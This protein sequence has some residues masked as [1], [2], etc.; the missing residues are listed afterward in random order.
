MPVCCDDVLDKRP[1]SSVAAQWVIQSEESTS[2][3]LSNV[4]KLDSLVE[5]Q[6]HTWMT[7]EQ[8]VAALQ[9]RMQVN[10][11]RPLAH[12]PTFAVRPPTPALLQIEL[13][14]LCSTRSSLSRKTSTAVPFVAVLLKQA[15]LQ[16]H[17]GS[18]YSLTLRCLFLK[19]LFM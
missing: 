7:C 17:H 9:M 1:G 13:R 5:P 6:R 3:T 11:A 16:T 2:G 4:L 14:V 15:C 12:W 10:S 19:T 18:Q 8:L